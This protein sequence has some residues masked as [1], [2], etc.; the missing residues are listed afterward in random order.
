MKNSQNILKAL[1]TIIVVSFISSG[2]ASMLM[3]GGTLVPSGYKVQKVIVAYRAEGTAPSRAQYFLVETDKGQAIFER[4]EDGSG[5]LFQTH[6]LD[7]QGDHFAG[8]VSLLPGRGVPLEG[9]GILFMKGPAYE[10]IVPLDRS[11]E[12]RK[13]VYP[14]GTYR[15]RKING[16]SRPV[17]NSSFTKPVARLIPK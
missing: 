13:F 12:A 5:A 9:S 4:S 1:L 17:P 11:K 15:I 6:W 14:K 10:F 2:C 7:D 8:W 3:K 16:I